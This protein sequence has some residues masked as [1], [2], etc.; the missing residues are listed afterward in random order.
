MSDLTIEFTDR[1]VVVT[2]WCGIN[3]A[4]PQDL[5]NFQRRQHD[6]G[7]EVT[8]IYCPLGHSHVPSGEGKAAKLERQLAWERDRAARL[9]GTTTRPSG[10]AS[11]S[12]SGGATTCRRDTDPQPW[13]PW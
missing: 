8:G 7:R 13:S 10:A 12:L 11:A 2:C 5:K 6:E 3:H 1:L 9:S 4:I